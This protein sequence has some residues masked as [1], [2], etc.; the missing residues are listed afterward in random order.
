MQH[1]L[2]SMSILIDPLKK[3]VRLEHDTEAQVA[4]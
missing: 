1:E 4:Y 2:D 3:H